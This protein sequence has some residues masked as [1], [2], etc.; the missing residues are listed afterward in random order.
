MKKKTIAI[1][2]PFI[3]AVVAI[4]CIA[5]I[6]YIRDSESF[7]PEYFK[8]GKFVAVNNTGKYYW[9]DEDNQ[10]FTGEYTE[11]SFKAKG[12]IGTDYNSDKRYRLYGELIYDGKVM[13]T[14]ERDFVFIGYRFYDGLGSISYEMN[15][16][17]TSLDGSGTEFIP[18]S[19]HILLEEDFS[20]PL[21]IFEVVDGE[22]RLEIG[23]YGDD[24]EE[25]EANMKRVN[26]IIV[27][28]GPTY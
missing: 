7:Y 4:A 16:T 2:V 22:I 15:S 27:E 20:K 14:K 17:N 10:C 13:M 18:N 5:V 21:A 26:E 23:Y 28:D 9:Y 12:I 24:L 6:F 19:C 25:A 11:V 3:V 8:V 1:L